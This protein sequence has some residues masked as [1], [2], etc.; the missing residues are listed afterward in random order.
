MAREG[1]QLTWAR[2]FGR[3]ADR[4]R[5]RLFDQSPASAW[6]RLE[7]ADNADSS[8]SVERDLEITVLLW[9]DE[10]NWSGQVRLKTARKR[11]TVGTLVDVI[12]DAQGK[13]FTQHPIVL[14]HAA[15]RGAFR[16][17]N[18]RLKVEEQAE[19][20]ADDVL[21]LI[22]AISIRDRLDLSDCRIDNVDLSRSVIEA[23][24]AADPDADRAASPL[25]KSP[26]TGGLWLSYACLRGATFLHSQ[27]QGADLRSADLSGAMFGDASLEGTEMWGANLTGASFHRTNLREANLMAAKFVDAR[28]LEADFGGANL[29]GT[30][31]QGATILDSKFVGAN[32]ADAH[33]EGVSF[34]SLK[35]G[36]L[37]R[38]RWS[39]AF[40]DR[41]RI[42]RDQLGEVGE[43]DESD[44][45][46]RAG[47]SPNYSASM[48]R[49]YAIAQEVYLLHKNNFNSIGRYADAS[50]AYQK[51]R[52]MERRS[53]GFAWRALEGRFLANF[54]RW[55][56]NWVACFDYRIWRASV[57]DFDGRSAD[58]IDLRDRL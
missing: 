1:F 23:R 13:I 51:E 21:T 41:T 54:G 36:K 58:R 43:N 24:W 52:E 12:L 11:L 34:E 28:L 50:W 29:F 9:K 19:L 46:R 45:R 15:H 38:V 32:L 56:A 44:M 5:V 26:D 22:D 48:S 31:W 55:L 47:L 10:G 42:R 17:A 14:A 53:L 57:A 3:L 6:T 37:A 20:S 18:I 7:S 35:P 8:E 39:G 16:W 33:V 25:W 30:D 4:L 27:L 2:E 49:Q 40:L